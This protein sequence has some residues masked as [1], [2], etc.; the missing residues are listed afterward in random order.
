ME[1][2]HSC[3]R[4]KGSE[5]QDDARASLERYMHYYTR[6]KTHEDSRK[7]EGELRQQL[8][9]KITELLHLR[10]NSAW[11]EINMIETATDTLF[12]CRKA[13]QYGYAFG[14][15]LFDYSTT[16]NDI[17]AGVRKFS[18]KKFAQMAQTIWEDN[19]EQLE[20]AT[21][22]L[23]KYLELP[24]E[25]IIEAENKKQIMGSSVLVDKR[26]Q[27]LFGILNDEFMELGSQVPRPRSRYASAAASN[28]SFSDLRRQHDEE[29]R[30]RKLQME[31][32]RRNKNRYQEDEDFELQKALLLS[33]RQQ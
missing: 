26:L 31:E 10:P 12:K 11:V 8:K 25:D 3:G 9:E 28:I 20:M 19:V 33:L 17:L 14:F 22:K 15:Y 32:S 18:N 27:A 30:K 29:E 2:S 5:N 6:Y 7:K 23:S 13:L 21:E 24:A 1:G 16:G 4:Y